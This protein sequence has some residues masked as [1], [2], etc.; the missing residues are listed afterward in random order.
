MLSRAWTILART[1]LAILLLAQLTIL[2]AVA[3]TSPTRLP[4][5]VIGVVAELVAGRMDFECREVT[6]DNRGRIRLAG[7]HLSDSEHPDDGVFGD[8]DLLPDW[9][10]LLLGKPDLIAMQLRARGT[11]GGA[12]GS[13][14]DD[15]VLRLSREDG[16]IRIQAAARAGAMV[17]RA[18]VTGSNEPEDGQTAAQQAGVPE[19]NR[20]LALSCLRGLRSVS[21]GLGLNARPGRVMLSGGFTENAAAL[22]P[23]PIQA[24]RGTLRGRWDHEL[25]LELMLNGLRVG[26]ATAG[27]AWVALEKGLR[28]RAMAEEVRHDGL[29][30]AAVSGAGR[31]Q[32]DGTLALHL[33]AATAESRLAT[34]V[35]IAGPSV[36]AHDMEGRLS[37]GDL[38][39]VSS[40]AQAARQTGVDLGG[41]IEI[42]GGEAN[43]ISGKFTSAGTS[44]AL[45][46]T[47]W[48]DLRPALVRPERVRP[49]FSGQLML[50]LAANRLALTRLDLAGIRGEIAGGLR[51]GDT[52]AINLRSSADN[53]VNPSCLNKL[54]GEWW[55]DLWS[56]FDLSTRRARPH[57]EVRVTGRWGDIESI[58]TTVRARLENFGFM[59]ARF[60]ET[61][62]WVFAHAG[63]SKVRIDTLR[64]ELDGEAAGD[65]RVTLRWD[66]RRPEWQGQPQIEAEGDLAPALAL[67][68]YDPAAAA[69]IRDWSF[70]NPRL[71]LSLGPAG[72][73]RLVLESTGTSSISGV[74]VD[75]LRLTATKPQD[76][77]GDLTLEATGKLSGGNARLSLTG[78]LAARN[79]L[80]LSVKEWN[81]TGVANLIEQLGGPKSEKSGP[82]ASRL[83]LQYEGDCDFGR[84]KETIGRGQVTL[85]D[86]NLKTIH[87]FGLL[88]SGLD[89]LGI[90]ISSY[91]LD[92]AEITF[93]CLD[94]RA[95]VDPLR[96]IGNDA[97]LNLKGTISLEDGA[98]DLSGRFQLKES[99][100]GP[101][102]FMNPN[103]LIT[104]MISVG[105]RGT[106]TQPEVRAKILD[107]K[108][109]K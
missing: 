4:A 107:V 47:G 32:A 27:R 37:A 29:V 78:D 69:R 103:R 102:K 13:A 105:V 96:F 45:G 3:H 18:D 10:G 62:L 74:K 41:F 6:I 91:P 46:E 101:L 82:D 17:L 28:L 99:P 26:N 72:P 40:I 84:P 1:L 15:L 85:F 14:I 64:G 104:N 106:I 88:S 94:R 67:R 76:P 19:W 55:V 80:Q 42:L 34:E 31:W 38:T 16:T 23:L 5:G 109:L 7:I 2:W 60:R 70:A 73:T 66:W 75:N 52:F 56:R 11:L 63:E 50:D 8:V 68:L 25:R 51:P 100:W 43:W 92:R 59:G 20:E 77:K 9:Q 21:G 53:P 89:A 39:R 61:D 98:L 24:A 90:G 44:F 65:A 79:H 54:L 48:G 71:R 57:A 12:D 97:S 58:H 93:R 33:S 95:E 36:R 86:P 22:S 83:T 81:R 30:D 87:L 49:G 108:L 35:E